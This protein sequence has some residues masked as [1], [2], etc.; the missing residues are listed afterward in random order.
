[1]EN[2]IHFDSSHPSSSFE[3]IGGTRYCIYCGKEMKDNSYY[4][5][6]D[7]V[8]KYGCDCKGALL[9]MDAMQLLQKAHHLKYKKGGGDEIINELKYKE[10]CTKL[11]FNSFL[12]SY[13]IK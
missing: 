6:Y 9:E 12:T 11:I 10:E 8:S 13:I 2:F 4:E 3:M 5:E 1:M 7:K